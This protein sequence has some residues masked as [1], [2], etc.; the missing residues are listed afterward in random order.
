MCGRYSLA[1]PTQLIS[2]RFR[3]DEMIA[4]P[5]PRYN[6]APTEEA[7]VV[8]GEAARRILR[9]MKWGLVPSWA[10]DPSIGAR[11][12]NAR[13]ETLEEKPAFR[14]AYRRRRCLVL[15]DGFY[16]WRPS[17]S[18]RGKLPVRFVLA[19]GEPFA[20]AG[21]WEEWRP[22]AGEPLRTF[23]IVTTAANAR[24]AACHDRMPVVLRPEGE[25]VWLAPE[26]G[27]EALAALLTPYPEAEM[28]DYPVSPRVNSAAHDS[29]ECIAEV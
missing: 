8:V 9:A 1:Q 12:I 27:R 29:P 21:L 5:A 20:L 15:A 10:K 7:A 18:G 28:R 2:R 3:L 19:D 16:E 26:S 4:E 24:V 6:I 11:L 14:S 13:S 25:E 23:T 17:P 22:A